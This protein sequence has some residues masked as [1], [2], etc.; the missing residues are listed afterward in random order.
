[1]GGLLILDK[2]RYRGG[3]WTN[4]NLSYALTY[5]GFVQPVAGFQFWSLFAPTMGSCANNYTGGVGVTYRDPGAA[6]LSVTGG[7]TT[8]AMPEDATLAGFFRSADQPITVAPS[9]TFFDLDPSVGPAWWP[10]FTVSQILKGL[11]NFE[12]TSPA[13]TNTNAPN[14]NQSFD[15]RWNG[16]GGDYMLFI[17]THYTD[18]AGTLTFVQEVTCA[19]PDNGAFTVPANAWTTWKQR[20]TDYINIQVVRIQERTAVLPMDRST[21]VGVSETWVVGAADMN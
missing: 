6:Q 10:S 16:S 3:Y 11:D 14:V 12:V 21:L 4:P 18:V 19:V 17:L 7:G 15:I 1:V 8:I 9:A 2:T 20:A 13:I 5:G